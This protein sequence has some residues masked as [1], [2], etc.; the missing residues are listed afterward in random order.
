MSCSGSHERR[1]SVRTTATSK[2]MQF[3]LR[4][5]RLDTVSTRHG[6]FVQGIDSVLSFD[7]EAQGLTHH[8]E[9]SYCCWHAADLEAFGRMA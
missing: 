6:T 2:P 9:E 4:G 1:Q 8:P 7:H 3:L 5:S